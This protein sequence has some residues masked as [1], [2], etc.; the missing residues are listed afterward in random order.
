MITPGSMIIHDEKEWA[1]SM[2]TIIRGIIS[3]VLEANSAL[4]LFQQYQ[5][6]IVGNEYRIKRKLIKN[7]ITETHSEIRD[8][9]R[10]EKLAAGN[11]DLTDNGRSYI[12]AMARVTRENADKGIYPLKIEEKILSISAK[13]FIFS[14]DGIYRFSKLLEKDDKTP[15]GAKSLKH[16]IDTAFPDLTGVRDTAHHT[17]DRARGIGLDHKRNRV[18]MTYKPFNDGKFVSDGS[19]ML[20]C[21]NGTKYSTTM[22]DGVTGTIDVSDESMVQLQ[23]IVQEA[24]NAFQWNGHPGFHP[25]L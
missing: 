9:D 16:N 10:N 14:I 3:L 25:G 20:G 7:Q 13:A 23:K 15:E 17:E 21:I 5:P 24:I 11:Y 6:K 12:S 19:L 22:S 2:Q 4:A 1:D 18:Q 8:R